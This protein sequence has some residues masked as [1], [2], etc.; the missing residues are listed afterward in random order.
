MCSKHHH[1]RHIT[2]CYQPL[3]V[4]VVLRTV[5]GKN[6]NKGNGSLIMGN[7][8]ENSS[9]FSVIFVQLFYLERS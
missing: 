5:S 7:C 9:R 4:Q 6:K 8:S 1:K 3:M 2:E